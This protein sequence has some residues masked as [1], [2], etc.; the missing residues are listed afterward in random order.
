MDFFDSETVWLNITNAALGLVVFVC[1]L[2]VA[3]GVVLEFL[4]R[5]AARS[6]V[7]LERDT[8]AFNLEHLGIVMNDGGEPIDEARKPSGDSSN[9]IRSEN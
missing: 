6:R 4:D 3:R 8:H 5:A 9:I 7:P 2:A 1:L